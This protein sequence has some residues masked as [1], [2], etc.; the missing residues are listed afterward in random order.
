M[1]A[2]GHARGYLLSVAHT[3]A[4]TRR[5]VVVAVLLASVLTVIT[6]TSPMASSA[7]STQPVRPEEGEIIRLY[8]SVL[9]RDPDQQGFDYWVTARVEGVSLAA[10]ADG[11]LNG[12]E[13]RRRFGAGTDAGFV[14]RA[15]RNV[16]GRPGD[17]AGTAYWVGQ[18]D[19]GLARTEMVLLFSES[20]E[21]RRRTGTALAEL[22]SFQV[23]VSS[24]DA[25]DL[26]ASWRTGCPVGHDQLRAVELD[27]VDF[28]G[29]HTRGTLVVHVDAVDEVAA[30]FSHLYNARYPI[31]TITPID[32]YGGDD[33]ASMAANN[34]SAFN[35][36]TVTGGRSWSRHA[37]GTS[38]DIN[39]MQ[40]PYVSSTVVLP[41]TGG[42]FVDRS[43]YH[44]AM[45]RPG[46][47]VTTAFA[48]AGW[49]WGGDFRSLKD[50][51]HFER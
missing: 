47:V 32:A 20:V 4:T 23:I 41:P 9:D 1:T 36:R 3:A 51:H 16:L 10:V 26:A 33:D 19:R 45:I 5:R 8:R 30:I 13:Y 34:T 18:L 39:P 25:D 21:H 12:S 7:A 24:V 6:A 46:D 22:P 49:R 44:P 11:F 28:A 17:Q 2:G 48:A 50:Y 15:Y 14:E 37:F 31:A 29:R 38:I 42:D 35:C 40:N 43:S 27:H